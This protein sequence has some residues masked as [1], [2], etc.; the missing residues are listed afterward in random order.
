MWDVWHVVGGYW[1]GVNVTDS[2]ISVDDPEEI[3]RFR[4]RGVRERAAEV[5]RVARHQDDVSMA[6]MTMAKAEWDACRGRG[7]SWACPCMNKG[8]TRVLLPEELP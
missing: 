6:D 5:I 4:D 7:G 2:G 1:K 3:A 8:C